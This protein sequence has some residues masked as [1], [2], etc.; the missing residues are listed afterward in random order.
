MSMREWF[1]RVQT[2]IYSRSVVEWEEFFLSKVATL[3]DFVR[4]NGE[5]A[6]GIG[7]LFGIF[8][9]LFFKLVII[10]AAVTAVI[11]VSI[12]IWADSRPER[13]GNP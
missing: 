6:A 2:F 5:K 7:F 1:Q 9:V 13:P 10:A 4:N 12:I 11:I 8:L 3:R